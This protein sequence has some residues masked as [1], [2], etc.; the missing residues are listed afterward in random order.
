MWLRSEGL[1]G[2]FNYLLW[3]HVSFGNI[4][5]KKWW[6]IAVQIA[7]FDQLLDTHVIG[8]NSNVLLHAKPIPDTGPDTLRHLLLP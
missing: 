1:S 6:D 4:S 2:L 7:N 5:A 8:N 3:L